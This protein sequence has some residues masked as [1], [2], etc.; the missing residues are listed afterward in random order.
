MNPPPDRTSEIIAQI[1]EKLRTVVL[2][3]VSADGEPEASIA[4]AVLGEGGALIVYVS[5]LAAHTRNLRATAR[6]SVLIAE[7]ESA[8]TQALARRRLTLACTAAA[9]ARDGPEFSPLVAAFR[10]RFGAT[11]DLLAAMPDFQLFRLAPQRGR[12]VVGFGQAFE[13]EPRDWS[14]KARVTV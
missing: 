5:G 13:I 9:V 3:T 10:A 4:G 7:D 8:A 1:R 12:L 11:I 2:G 6:A 14:V